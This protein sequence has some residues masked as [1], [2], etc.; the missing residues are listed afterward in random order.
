[1]IQRSVT[2]ASS[3][4]D[5]RHGMMVVSQVDLE[6]R[7]VLPSMDCWL[8]LSDEMDMELGSN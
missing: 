3:N 6:A 4:F 7:T 2:D 1:M 5:K 8:L